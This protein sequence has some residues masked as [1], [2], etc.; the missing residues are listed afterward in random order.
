MSVVSSD[1]RAVYLFCPEGKDYD[2]D[3]MLQLAVLKTNDPNI[4]EVYADGWTD[5]PNNIDELITDLPKYSHV[6]LL[7]LEGLTEAHLKALVSAAEIKCA[8]YNTEWISSANSNDFRALCTVIRARE[9]YKE[10]RSLNIRAGM[11]RTKK[12]VGSLPFG[13]TRLEDGTI[14]EIPEQIALARKVAEMYKAG[15]PVMQISLKT[16][17]L[18]TPRQIYGLMNHWGVKRG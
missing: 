14:Q 4:A 13:H 11:K 7:T 5:V 16:E 1:Q 12:H 15:F 10:L 8:L 2:Y 18:L 3:Q 6:Y 17:G 9:Y